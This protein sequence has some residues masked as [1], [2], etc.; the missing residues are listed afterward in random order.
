MVTHQMAR[1]ADIDARIP[2]GAQSEGGCG[3]ANNLNPSIRTRSDVPAVSVI[4]VCGD[5]TQQ[6]GAGFT[7]TS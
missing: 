5:L 4:S 6:L 2:E 1:D 3:R 7:G